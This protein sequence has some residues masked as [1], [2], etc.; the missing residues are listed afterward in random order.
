MVDA[1][2]AFVGGLNIIDDLHHPEPLL[3]RFDYG[4][5]V[6]G[7]LL[8]EIH[9]A[10][11]HLWMLVAW[12]RI[13]LGVHFPFDML[14]ALGVAVGV[15]VLVNTVKGQKICYKLAAMIEGTFALAFGR[16]RS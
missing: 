16:K 3:P 1:R 7:P 9:A 4:V 11:K 6:E 8:V 14:G 15:M 5:A 10:A 2:I 12:A 13:Y